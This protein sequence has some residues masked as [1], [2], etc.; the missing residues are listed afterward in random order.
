MAKLSLEVL[1]LVTQW[2]V[3]RTHIEQLA[4][5]KKWTDKQSFDITLICEEWF[6]NIVEHGKCDLSTY[7]NVE[8][9]QLHAG[10][11]RMYFSDAGI[12]FSP[13]EKPASTEVTANIGQRL[14][15]LGIHFIRSKISHYHYSYVNQR[16]CV[17]MYYSTIEAGER[18]ESDGHAGDRP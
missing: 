1:P 15:G 11:I 2:D 18:G 10:D 9:E 17:A 8:V 6:M 5:E 7:I 16:N 13:F 12:P 4:L 14:G 3:I